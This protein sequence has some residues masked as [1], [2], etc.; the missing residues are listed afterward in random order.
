[1]STLEENEIVLLTYKYMPNSELGTKSL[2]FYLKWQIHKHEF[3]IFICKAM[4][5]TLKTII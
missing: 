5:R 4:I 1:M 3:H 2:S